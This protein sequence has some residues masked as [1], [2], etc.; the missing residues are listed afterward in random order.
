MLLMII[1]SIYGAALHGAILQQYLGEK[2]VNIAVTR[3][4]EDIFRL[5]CTC[6]G[7]FQQGGQAIRTSRILGDVAVSGRGIKILLGKASANRLPVVALSLAFMYSWQLTLIFFCRAP[8]WIV[9]LRSSKK[10]N[11]HQEIAV[12][13]RPFSGGIQGR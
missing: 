4:R 3:I 9:L 5:S 8:R 7:I 12:V 10:T 2:I 11:R 1:V 13:T 6:R